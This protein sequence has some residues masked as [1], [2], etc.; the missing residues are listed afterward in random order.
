MQKPRVLVSVAVAAFALIGLSA[1]E[2]KNES[3]PAETA[4]RQIDQAAAATNDKL[5]QTGEKINE[6]AIEFRK[7]VG[8]KMEQAGEKIQQSAD[9]NKDADQ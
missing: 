1:C 7:K 3:G 9:R 8:E 4:G 2:K 6:G 5:Q